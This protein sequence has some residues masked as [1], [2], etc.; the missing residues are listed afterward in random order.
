[1][2]AVYRRLYEGVPIGKVELLARALGQVQRF[3]EGRLTLTHLTRE[4]Y[5]L[6]GAEEGYSEGIVDHLRAVAG[7]RV[8][9]LVRELLA[10]DKA[11]RRKVSLRAADAA[12]DVSAMARAHGGGGHR[13]AAGF[14]TEMSLEELVGDLRARLAE[15]L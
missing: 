13:Q 9:V 6:S 14:T 15:Q 5:L 7:T 8:A 4:D 10:D 11:G 1:V 2:H 3:D 12:V